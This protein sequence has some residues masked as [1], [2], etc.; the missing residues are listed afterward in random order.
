MLHSSRCGRS[1]GATGRGRAGLK[2]KER[3]LSD[4]ATAHSKKAQGLL[5]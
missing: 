3:K 1:A 5:V 2:E 4:T